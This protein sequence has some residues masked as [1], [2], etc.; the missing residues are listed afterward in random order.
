LSKHQP[1]NVPRVF[2][3]F[4]FLAGDMYVEFSRVSVTDAVF[5]G[6]T[7]IYIYAHVLMFL[8]LCRCT[9]TELIGSVIEPRY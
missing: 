6:L 7:H 5:I 9:D 3:L 2:L 4:L 8:C 1:P